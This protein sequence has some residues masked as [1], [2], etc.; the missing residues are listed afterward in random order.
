VYVVLFSWFQLLG[1]PAVARPLVLICGIVASVVLILRAC[2]SP[3]RA[4][5]W[6]A[7]D[8]TSGSL[9]AAAL[10]CNLL[11]LFLAFA[12]V[13]TPLW[14]DDGPYHTELIDAYRTGVDPAPAAHEHAYP[15][16]YHLLVAGLLQLV[17]W[18]DSAYGTF[19]VSV[20]LAPLGVL[21]VFALGTVVW[22]VPLAAAIGALLAALTF[23]HPYNPQF[24]GF[25]PLAA[26]VVLS[27]G[28]WTCAVGYGRDQSV[29]W[30]AL[31]ALLAAGI[32]L[33]HGTEVYTAALGVAIILIAFAR[34]LSLRR[35]VRDA[36]FAILLST[37]LASPYV[38]T[39]LGWASAGGAAPSAVNW[40]SARAELDLDEQ[41]VGL[42]GLMLVSVSSGVLLDIPVRVG[43]LVAG[44]WWTLRSR[45]G[46]FVA[47]LALVF[48]A[49]AWLFAFGESSLVRRLYA[50][51]FPWGERDRMAMAAAVV[52][53]LIEAAAVMA[54]WAKQTSNGVLPAGRREKLILGALTATFLLNV[55]LLGA[56]LGSQAR[57]MMVF[58][59][60]DAAA[61]AW[62]RDHADDSAVLATD[63]TVDAGIW[64]PYKA[65]VPT[66]ITRRGVDLLSPEVRTVLENLS[67]LDT[68]P[69]AAASACE[70]G[71]RYVYYGSKE[72]PHVF[73]R[74][75]RMARHFPPLDDLRRSPVLEEVFTSGEAAVFRVNLPC[76]TQR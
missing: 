6:L 19:W 61:M 46:L 35:A 71:I 54:L 37:I 28:I 32:V 26:G 5:E 59:E 23:Q 33:V 16:G 66:L 49:L 47:A 68:V 42:I 13:Q 24:W 62:V 27:T 12:S 21:A 39:L 51:T 2:R 40:E 10:A 18:I 50:L 3:D 36:A 14:N 76:F 64:A 45:N 8:R 30:V 74:P 17:P 7:L 34:R 56:R 70:L 20:G 48:L 63:W 4:L 31:A 52:T 75:E 25:W 1:V 57:H 22:Q 11:I 72:T 53:P 67:R 41:F 44:L 38:P 65:G 9:L 43:L 15:R 69:R 29:R 73:G 58:T 60:H 55:V